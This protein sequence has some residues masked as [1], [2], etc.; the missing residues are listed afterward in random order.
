MDGASGMNHERQRIVRG[1]RNYGGVTKQGESNWINGQKEAK[2]Q[3]KPASKSKF[4]RL[5]EKKK[6]ERTLGI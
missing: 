2:E 4:K 5:F 3:K 6:Q 1:R